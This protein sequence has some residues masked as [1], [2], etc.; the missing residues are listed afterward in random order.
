MKTRTYAFLGGCLLPFLAANADMAA[1]LDRMAVEDPEFLFYADMEGDFASAAAFMS[2]AY[3]AYLMTN[4]DLPP[5]PVN[6]ASLM[7]HLGLSTMQSLTASSEPRRGGGFKNQ[8]M[9]RFEGEPTGLFRIAGEANEPFTLQDTAPADADLVAEFSFNGVALYTIV[10]NIIIDVMG[11]LGENLIDTQINQPLSEG[12][13]TL[14]DLINRLSTRVQLAVKPGTPDGRKMPPAMSLFSGLAA[15]RLSNLADMVESLA[16]M[17]EQAGFARSGSAD[18]PSWSFSVPVPDFPVT[19]HIRTVTG[20][21]DLLV[22]L[23]EASQDWFLNAD[24]PISASESFRE[25]TAWFPESGLSFWYATERLAALQ[26]EN[27]D[28]QLPPNERLVPV[29]SALKSFL[30]TY[31]GVQAGVTFIEEDA[32]RAISYQP[33][34]YKTSLALTGVIVPM[35][36][37]AGFADALEDKQVE[38]STVVEEQPG[39]GDAEDSPPSPAD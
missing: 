19:V 28:A 10:R 13:P 15:A 20:T 36:I 24:T 16:P 12:G 4:P 2:D 8:L 3:L 5:I 38:Q 11:P 37:A 9:I 21:N 23:S 33:T 22:T 35:G 18:S 30:M 26:I 31:T 7:D 6:F 39:Q 29:L 25:Q 14:A 17:L 32:Y 1:A 34:S 27:L